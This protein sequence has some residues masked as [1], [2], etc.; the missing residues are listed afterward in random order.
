MSSSS[1]LRRSMTAT[2]DEPE[3]RRP[4]RRSPLR[5][6]PRGPAHHAFKEEVTEKPA[7]VYPVLIAAAVVTASAIVLFMMIGPKDLTGS[8]PEGTSSTVPVEVLIGG[9]PLRIPANYT[10]FP[11]DRQGGALQ[12]VSLYVL[13]P[14][15]TPYTDDKQDVFFSNA[16]NSPVVYF[17]LRGAAPPLSEAE[18]PEAI[19][20]PHVTEGSGA[21]EPGGLTRYE[22]TDDS[23]FAGEDLFVGKD[24]EGGAVVFRCSRRSGMV[25]SP[26]C[27]RDTVL[28]NGLAL[29]YRF[30]R[31][32]LQYWEGI[33]RGL[34]TLVER[35]GAAG[36]GT[37]PG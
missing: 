29:S 18:R 21:E 10:Q 28:A 13:L 3:R 34:R 11:R 30:K 1:D 9:L 35:F 2:Y 33:D 6:Q 17:E 26:N 32:Y 27:W 5:R 20:M 7:W 16:P 4:Q 23:P 36:V 24:R 15:F 12:S 19:Y 25:P 14:K 37:S 8:R 22:F 31:P